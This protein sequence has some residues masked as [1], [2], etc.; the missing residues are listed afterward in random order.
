MEG[1]FGRAPRLS[2]PFCTLPA[3][4]APSAPL[5]ESESGEEENGG[6]REGLSGSRSF[7][8]DKE[9]IPTRLDCTEDPFLDECLAGDLF[10]MEDPF[11][12]VFALTT[13]RNRLREELK[14]IKDRLQ[15]ERQVS[16]SLRQDMD[17]MSC[18]KETLLSLLTPEQFYTYR[19]QRFIGE[20][21]FQSTP[22]SSSVEVVAMQE[23]MTRFL[24]PEE[25]IQ[26]EMRQGGPGDHSEDGVEPPLSL[27]RSSGDLSPPLKIQRLDVAVT[28][29]PAAPPPVPGNLFYLSTFGTLKRDQEVVGEYATR[30]DFYLA[31]GQSIQTPGSIMHLCLLVGVHPPSYFDRGLGRIYLLKKRTGEKKMLAPPKTGNSNGWR[32][33]TKKH[34]NKCKVEWEKR[35]AAFSIHK[36]P[37][38]CLLVN[39]SDPNPDIE[40]FLYH[41]YAQALP[42]NA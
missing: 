14:L 16:S 41:F 4:S 9:E 40:Y 23:T 13:E 24:I 5:W 19:S 26:Q 18:E 25:E 17:T 39:I 12:E 37:K 11:G 8:G 20:I 6:W 33:N 1:A 36:S 27:L 28:A 42:G 22:S 10:S 2:A 7:G 29:A 3:P 15:Q 32:M 31:V 30:N 21:S 34:H 35:R 38:R